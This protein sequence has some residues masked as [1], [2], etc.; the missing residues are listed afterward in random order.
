MKI[1][2]LLLILLA[3]FASAATAGTTQLDS[4]DYSGAYI[5]AGAGWGYIS[6]LPTGTT[7][8]NAGFGYNFNRYLALEAQWAAFP[9]SQWGSLSNYN[10]Y[11]LNIKAT[12][13]VTNDWDFYG[14]LG[15]GLGYSSWSGTL[16]SPGVYN[17]AGSATSWIGQGTLGTSLAV[18]AGFALYL[19]DSMYLP[20]VGSDGKFANTNAVVFGVQY[21]F[22]SPVVDRA[23]SASSA[24]PEVTVAPDIHSSQSFAGS[25]PAGDKSEQHLIADEV[26]PLSTT[27]AASVNQAV[28]PAKPAAA[29]CITTDC[30]RG[31]TADLAT[32]NFRQRI[33][34][35]G[36]GRQYIIVRKLDTLYSIARY[37]GVSQDKL[38]EINHLPASGKIEVGSRLYF[39]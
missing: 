7:A 37:S 29:L 1:P 36:N 33:V 4:K 30:T 20:L 23:S 11:D 24:A 22:A 2:K 9:G 35:R 15:S 27:T 19:E 10:V 25:L 39:N 5:N 17:S 3:I 14:K 32:T 38:R 31:Y 6:N 18:G 13:P 12:L 34:T 28:A 21:N 8:L 16:G 26:P